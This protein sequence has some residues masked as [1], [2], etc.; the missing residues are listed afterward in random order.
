MPQGKVRLDLVAVPPAVSLAQDVAL[1]NKLGQNPVGGSFS[2]AY[3]SS[4]VAQA[5]ARVMGHAYKDVGVMC[6]KIPAGD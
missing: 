2:D 3:R 6:Q 1:F 5:D 4:D